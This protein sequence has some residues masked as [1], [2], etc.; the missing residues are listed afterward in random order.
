MFELENC[1]N[2]LLARAQNAVAQEFRAAL[3]PHDLTPLQCGVLNSLYKQEWM[4]LKELSEELF[5]NASTMTGVVDRLEAKNLVERRPST[6][7]RRALTIHLTDKGR[8]MEGITDPLIREQNRLIE[9][10]LSPEENRLLKSILLK[11][12]CQILQKGPC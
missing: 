3:S 12:S 11:L 6:Q 8:E 2:Y 5:V 7:D 1:T 10:R 9:S 4:G